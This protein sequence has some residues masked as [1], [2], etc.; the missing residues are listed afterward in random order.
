MGAWPPPALAPAPAP[1]PVWKR[2][3]CRKRITQAMA[4]LCEAMKVCLAGMTT[5]SAMSSCRSRVSSTASV[6]SCSPALGQN[7]DQARYR[8][9]PCML[10]GCTHRGA[11]VSPISGGPCRAPRAR[12][13]SD[14]GLNHS[15]PPLPA[16]TPQGGGGGAHCSAAASSPAISRAAPKVACAHQLCCSGAH[17]RQCGQQWHHVRSKGVTIALPEGPHRRSTRGPSSASSLMR[18]ARALPL[19]GGASSTE[20]LHAMPPG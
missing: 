15:K 1:V 6:P 19:L 16:M 5:K 14:S 7:T 4:A 20:P 12:A 3:C 18:R 2:P 11:R 8:R 9:V 10:P 17:V 13:R